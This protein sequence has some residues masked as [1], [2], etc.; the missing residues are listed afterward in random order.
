[1]AYHFCSLFDSNF[2]L[3]GL[4]LYRSLARQLQDFSFSVLCLD[5][6]CY[7]TLQAL[8]DPHIR[9]IPLQELEHWEP[10]L[11]QARQ[12]RSL[13][14]YYF[15]LSPALPLYLLQTNE[16]MEIIT[17]MDADLFFYHS[18]EPLFQE[19][20]ERSILVIEHRFPPSLQGKL[21]YGRFNVQYQSFRRDEQGLRCLEVWHEQCLEWCYDRLEANRFAD[22][23]YLDDW[24]DRY[25]RLV[26][27]QLPGAGLAPWNWANYR[28]QIAG[29]HFLVD[30]QPL[31][32][33]HYH[34]L[35]ILSPHLVSH[36]MM[37]FGVMPRK[38]R[39]WLYGRYLRELQATSA[40]LQQAGVGKFVVQDRKLHFR[41]QDGRP[42]LGQWPGLLRR[43]W[44][45]LMLLRG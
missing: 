26:I 19:L 34:A 45:Q 14:E 24:P 25:D 37:D 20:E 16:A 18:P 36:G 38:Y 42:G 6:R 28:L 23:K 35:K 7:H 43:A 5:E 3:R 39:S 12:N 44:S 32:F 2:L 1:M 10:R 17:F 4:T 33:Y 40:W 8:Q 30:T 22:Q 31:L 9:P 11:L 15:T 29:N 27:S 13:I 21:K 41:V